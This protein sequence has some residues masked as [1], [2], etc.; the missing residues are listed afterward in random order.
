MQDFAKIVYKRK[1]WKRCRAAYIAFRVSVDGGLCEECH[2]ALGYIVHHK[3]PLTASNINDSDIC[4]GHRNLEYV[5]KQC[6]DKF[7]GHGVN[8]ALTPTMLFDAGGDPTPPHQSIGAL[9][10]ENRARRLL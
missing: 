1:Q 7:D 10:V 3:E 6:H 8:R 4:Y 2:D 5:C 9:G